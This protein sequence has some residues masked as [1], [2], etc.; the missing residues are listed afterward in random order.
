MEDARS[1]GVVVIVDRLAGIEAALA[2][3][4]DGDIVVVA[5]KGHEDYQL[6][7]NRVLDL[8]DRRIVRDW[9]EGERS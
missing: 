3:A 1:G 8:D 7:G 2:A 4:A 5:G 9:V 6:V